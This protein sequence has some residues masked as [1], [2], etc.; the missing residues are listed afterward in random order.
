MRSHLT[1]KRCHN[2][3]GTVERFLIP[4]AWFFFTREKERKIFYRRLFI[5]EWSF[6]EEVRGDKKKIS[7]AEDNRDMS[8]DIRILKMT[9]L[10]RKRFSHESTSYCRAA[11]GEMKFR[12]FRKVCDRWQK[13]PARWRSK[14]KCPS[15]KFLAA[16]YGSFFPRETSTDAE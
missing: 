15:R 16:S 8:R 14:W 2:L 13:F 4:R 7:N 10:A 6:S 12:W 1:L 3:A 11:S 9:L 5:S